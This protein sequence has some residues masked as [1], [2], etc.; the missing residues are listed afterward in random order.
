[1]DNE[2][3]MDNE[4]VGA[5]RKGNLTVFYHRPSKDSLF[6]RV[7]DGGSYDPEFYQPNNVAYLAISHGECTNVSGVEVLAQLADEIDGLYNVPAM[8]IKNVPLV[9]LA[10]LTAD[11]LER[12]AAKS[13]DRP[14]IIQTGP[15]PKHR[16]FIELRQY[17]PRLHVRRASNS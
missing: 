9:G 3:I 2:T 13:E 14:A 4:K 15:R 10:R 1:M 6:L 12:E 7:R 17:F 16:P 11:R 8:R 5:F